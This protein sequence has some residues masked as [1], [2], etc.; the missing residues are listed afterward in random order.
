MERIY[1]YRPKAVAPNTNI[2][3]YLSELGYGS[4]LLKRLKHTENSVLLNDRPAMLNSHL[5]SGDILKISLNEEGSSNVVP[6]NIPIDIVFE[7]E[8]ILIVNKPAGMPIHPS[9]DHYEDTL[10]NAV[11]YH[12]LSAGQDIVFR[13]LTRLDRDTSGLV[14][15]AKNIYVAGLL[16]KM[17]QNDEIKKTYLALAS[18]LFQDRI[19][20]VNAPIAR[21]E[22]SILERCVDYENG[23]DSITHYEVIKAFPD[24][25]ISLLKLTLDTG[26]T[27]QIRV[28]MKH[29]NHPLIGDF[30]YN[31]DYTYISRQALHCSTMQFSHPI[32]KEPL[33]FEA[34]YPSDFIF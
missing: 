25:N 7:D 29:I 8:D 4:S 1:V 20:T 10:G 34:P 5:K 13:A 28:H 11:A 32:K 19:G 17:M 21:K 23:A 15:I 16:S 22:G 12:C 3:T 27:H 2:I 26:R 14:L 18:G 9:M 30:L 24:K 33:L 31:P 6:I